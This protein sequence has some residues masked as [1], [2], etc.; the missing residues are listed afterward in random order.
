MPTQISLLDIFNTE[1]SL[2][3]KILGDNDSYVTV[4]INN[5]CSMFNKMTK[6]EIIKYREEYYSHYL[7]IKI[8]QT[9]ENK[10]FSILKNHDNLSLYKEPEDYEVELTILASQINENNRKNILTKMINEF[11]DYVSEYYLYNSNGRRYIMS[12]VLM[13]EFY[14]FIKNHMKY[15][16]TKEDF[17]EDE[18]EIYDIIINNN[19]DLL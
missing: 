2:S 15:Q 17:G 4:R 16:I 12:G 7:P 8:E 18:E 19:N 5:T 6:G 13:K 11:K 3:D 10:M 1:S 9:I 14:N